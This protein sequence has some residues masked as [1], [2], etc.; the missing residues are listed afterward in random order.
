MTTP[1]TTYR[2]RRSTFVDAQEMARA[3]PQS[4]QA[5]SPLDLHDIKVG[6]SIKVCLNNERFWLSVIQVQ[7]DRIL[8]KV[9]NDLL[10]NDLRYGSQ[11][12]V[13]KRHVH[14]VIEGGAATAYKGKA[15]A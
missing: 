9:T 1:R 8:G 11:I 12:V 13:E 6:D 14:D 15:A 4:F 7:G 10:F 5:P 3:Y 2:T